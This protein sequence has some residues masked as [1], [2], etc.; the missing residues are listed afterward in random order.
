MDNSSSCPLGE[1]V[2]PNVSLKWI[3]L[4]QRI[5]STSTATAGAATAGAEALP[6]GH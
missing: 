1:A 3:Q 6:H 5:C 2:L 4:P